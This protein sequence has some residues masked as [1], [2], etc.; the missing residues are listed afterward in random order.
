M[1]FEFLDGTR[2]TPNDV[3]IGGLSC[4]DGGE[5]CVSG[6][7]IQTGAT[8]AGAGQEMSKGFHAYWEPY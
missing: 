2:Q 4:E 6:F 3:H 5:R 7:A 1:V 8:D